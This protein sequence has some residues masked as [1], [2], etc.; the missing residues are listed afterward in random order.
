MARHLADGRDH[1]LVDRRPAGL[2]A[3]LV[4]ALLDRP[5]EDAAHLRELARLLRAG[6]AGRRDC[7]DG[8]KPHRKGH[9][10]REGKKKLHREGN[11]NK[12][13]IKTSRSRRNRAKHC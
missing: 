12:D 2:L 11:N 3:R 4:H 8:K 6:A 13:K 5:G 9:E 7:K 10:G 1:A